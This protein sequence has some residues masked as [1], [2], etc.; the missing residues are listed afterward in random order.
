MSF[1]KAEVS[2]L[3]RP[4]KGAAQLLVEGRTPEIFFRSM[5]EALGWGE[6][7]DVRSFGSKEKDTLQLYLEVFTAKAAFK[8][9]VRALGVVRDAEAQP[10]ISAFQS[11]SAA[12][13]AVNIEPPAAI[14]QFGNR[15]PRA[16]IFV[17]PDGQ[18]PGMLETLCLD[19]IRWKEKE[20][21]REAV[22][23]C[24][25]GYINCLVQAGVHAKTPD[26]AKLAA[27]LAGQDVRDPL[28]GRAAQQGIFPWGC[29]VFE[30]LRTFLSQLVSM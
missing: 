24:M 14:E 1:G 26:K 13:R 27:Y 18:R 10:A 15:Q 11:V 23:D 12:L 28:A 2:S 21:G 9:K 6:H 4:I 17:L 25:D 29:P 22:L 20:A 19:V 8:E 16:G 3:D 5:T 30:P 7:V